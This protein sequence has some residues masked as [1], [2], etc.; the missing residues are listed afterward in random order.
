MAVK[1]YTITYFFYYWKIWLPSQNASRKGG[2]V[3]LILWIWM[4]IFHFTI[5]RCPWVYPFQKIIFVFWPFRRTVSFTE[6]PYI[7]NQNKHPSKQPPP[8]MCPVVKVLFEYILERFRVPDFKIAF[9]NGVSATRKTILSLSFCG[10][11]LCNKIFETQ[12]MLGEVGK[13]TFAYTRHSPTP[14]IEWP[15]IHLHQNWELDIRLQGHWTF[16]YIKTKDWTFAYT[17]K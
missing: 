8:H 17:S 4:K 13:L 5:F 15:D 14:L 11:F 10:L 12:Q 16:A 3:N 9:R 6:D 2:F 1:T 7:E